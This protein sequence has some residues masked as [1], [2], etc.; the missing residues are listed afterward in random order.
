MSY[1]TKSGKF[2]GL[3]QFMENLLIQENHQ[4]VIQVMFQ[5]PFKIRIGLLQSLPP[6]KWKL[7]NSKSYSKTKK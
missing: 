1:K 6:K 3:L 7:C 2:Y 4:N 5:Q